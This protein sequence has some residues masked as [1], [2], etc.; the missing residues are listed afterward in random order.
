MGCLQGTH[1]MQAFDL[2]GH[3]Q[4]AAYEGADYQG[5]AAEIAAC[6]CD[7]AT[8]VIGHSFGATV[9]L[10]LAAMRPELVSRLSLIE[11]VFFAAASEKAQADHAAQLIPFGEMI[12]RGALKDAAR[13]FN[14]LW[15]AG[16]WAAIPTAQQDYMA[17]RIHL[18]PLASASIMQDPHGLLT[19]GLKSLSCPVDLIEGSESH[20][21][22]GSILD[23]LARALPQ[24]KRTTIQGAGHMA[25]LSHPR[26]VARALTDQV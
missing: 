19:G 15:G 3:G 17:Q 24:A 16:P 14:K 25:P 1:Q 23:G 21:I 10:R 7:G 18:I 9:A 2:P 22:I 4:S 20:P 26:D 11:P 13:F 6:F 5:R 12:E 8:H